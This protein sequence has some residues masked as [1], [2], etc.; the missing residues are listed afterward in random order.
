[1]IDAPHS[2]V[3]PVLGCALIVAFAVAAHVAIVDG[4]GKS[5]I[6]A[7]LSLIPVAAFVVLPV[8]R[9]RRPLIAFLAVAA[10]VVVVLWIGWPLLERHFP[11][12]FF[13]E[14]AGANLLLAI[15]FG[16]TLVRTRDELCTRFARLLHNTLPPD[17][18]RYTRLVTFAWT[19]FFG[20]MFVL[21]CLLYF[22]G[23]MAVWSLF[24]NILSPIL[25][26]GMFLGE[27]LVR[28]RVLP[29]WESTG[30]LSGIRAFTR[31]FGAAQA[32]APR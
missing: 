22:A 19:I 29:K 10:A 15:V 7:W 4:S 18:E 21:S 17:V 26:A 28:R 12:V 27:Y 32:D 8:R 20:V 16:R 9:S 2:R 25:I 24:A 30:V 14:H 31:H 5:A 6:G 1:M 11:S 3:I 23:F 13:V